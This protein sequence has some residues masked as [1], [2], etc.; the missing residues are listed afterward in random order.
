MKYPDIPEKAWYTEYVD[1]VT[2]LGLMEGYEDGTFHP[3]R[4]ASRAELATVVARLCEKLD[5]KL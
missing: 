4:A 1:Y 3:D 5:I 2:E